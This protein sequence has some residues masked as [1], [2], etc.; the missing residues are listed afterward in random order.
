MDAFEQNRRLGRGV[1]VIGYDRIWSSRAAGRFKAEHF[2]LIAGAGF[3]HVRINLHPYAHM[4]PDGTIPA[5]WLETLDWAVEECRKVGLLAILDMHEFTAMAKDPIG[6]KE[7]LLAVWRQLAP[8]YASASDDVLFELLN[9]PNGLLTPELWNDFLKEPLSIVRETN[10]TRTVILGP[11]WWNGID[12]LA[13]L[14]LPED[15]RNLIVTVHYYHPMPFT[16]QGAAWAEEHKHLSGIKW[17]G[18]DDEVAAIRK[19]FEGV[20][21]WAKANDRPIYL[22]EFGAYEVGDMDSRARYTAAVARE[23]ERLGWSWGYWQFDSDF[24][25][26]NIDKQQWVE[27]VLH[28][29]VPV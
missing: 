26:Y 9:E 15:D 25:V 27:P 16:H 13:D 29:L 22:G 4:A 20:Q 23:A 24:V 12:H 5:H 3:Q 6:L 1:N 18:T 17:N 10:P 7:R 8:R 19:D 21:T 28:A 2:G 14:R 11:A